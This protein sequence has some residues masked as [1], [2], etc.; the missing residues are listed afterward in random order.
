MT[1][2]ISFSGKPKSELLKASSGER[3]APYTFVPT[4]LACNV[5]SKSAGLTMHQIK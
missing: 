4:F 1:G 3:C 5:Q 2:K